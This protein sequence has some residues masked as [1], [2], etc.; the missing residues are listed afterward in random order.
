M[1][2]KTYF[3]TILVLFIVMS[4][5][6]SY[7]VVGLK[8]NYIFTNQSFDPLVYSPTPDWESDNPHYSTGCALTDINQ[9]GWLDIVV[10]DGNDILQGRLNVCYNNQG[11]FPTTA[12]WQSDGSCV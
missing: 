1:I 12:D 9:D 3:K 7:S 8:K 4:I 6:L 10:A 11:S 5:F 2:R